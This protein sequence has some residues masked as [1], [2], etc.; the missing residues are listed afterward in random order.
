M[1]VGQ[2]CLFVMARSLASPADCVLSWL[3]LRADADDGFSRVEQGRGSSHAEKP[4]PILLRVEFGGR[5]LGQAAA[6]PPESLLSNPRLV[7]FN[8]VLT[9]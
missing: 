6:F 3:P 4:L 9:S 7:P 5:G 2:M 1:G 8:A